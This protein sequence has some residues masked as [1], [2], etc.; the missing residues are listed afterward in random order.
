MQASSG[1]LY[2]LFNSP[3]NLKLKNIK[4]I[5]REKKGQI[6]Q[7]SPKCQGCGVDHSAKGDQQRPGPSPE[8][9]RELR[10]E[11]RTGMGP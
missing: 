2:F 11:V 9:Q 6:M 7:G 1:I 5:Q 3:V 8:S 10:L 4:S